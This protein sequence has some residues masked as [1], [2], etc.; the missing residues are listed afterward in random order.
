MT[1]SQALV[2]FAHMPAIK[3]RLQLLDECGLGYIHLGQSA[4]TLSGG[5]AQRIKLARELGKKTNS[6]TL[7]ILDEP[8]IGL[9]F[10]DVEKLITI[11]MRLVERGNTVV[12]IEHNL[13]V[14]KCADYVIDLGPE[15]GPKEEGSSRKAHQRRYAMPLLPIPRGFSGN[16]FRVKTSRE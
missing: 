12:V 3:Q 1:V 6:N 15:G 9:H 14:I 4:T 16:T 5:E 8:T 13:D 10:A 2:F 7:Y 11:L